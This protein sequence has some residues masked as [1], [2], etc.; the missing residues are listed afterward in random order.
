M[1]IELNEQQ[2]R[3]L[4]GRDDGPALVVNPATAERFILVPAAVYERMKFVL[5]DDFDPREFYPL[6]DRIM[7]DDDAND[8]HLDAYQHFQRETRS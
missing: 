4:A 6:V 5:E 3:I 2:Q 1:Q 8:P 7:A